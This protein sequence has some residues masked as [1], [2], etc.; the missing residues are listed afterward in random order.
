MATLT[1][2]PAAETQAQPAQLRAQLRL[3]EMILSGE[4]PGGSRIAE[5]NLVQKL[6]LSR[7]PIRGALQ[8]LE[9]EGLL[10]ALPNRG[11]AVRVFSEREIGEA[12][13]LR[14]MIEGFAARLAAERGAPPVVLN[15]ARVVLRQIDA[16]LQQARLTDADFSTY[17]ALNQS[18]HNLLSELAGSELLQRELERAASMPFA[19]PSAFVVAQANSADARDMF[20]V[21]QHQHW[22]VLD[23][24]EHGEGMRAESVMREHSRLAQHN[25]RDAVLHGSARGLPGVQLIRKRNAA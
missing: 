24:I 5:L 4:L 18:F 15:E 14:G 2:L 3:R 23:A 7:T 10:Q 11:Y 25:L 17:V 13:E 19:S 20:I 22:Q 16:L 6:G 12:I 9:Q 21:A 1:R 8:R